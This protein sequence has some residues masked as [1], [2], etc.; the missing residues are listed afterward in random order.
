MRT[1]SGRLTL[2]FAAAVFAV[3]AASA[4]YGSTALAEQRDKDPHGALRMDVQ[5]ER[6][7]KLQGD[8]D[9]TKPPPGADPVFWNTLL[10]PTDNQMT[11][12]RIAL[13]QRLYF[14]KKLSADGT[15]ACATCHDVSRGFTDQ[16][17]VAEGIGDQLGRRN[18]PT[19]MN[20]LFMETQ[21]WDGRA[22]SL[23]KQAELP[24]INPI[25]MGQ[26]D[27]DAAV[28]SIKDD[29]EYRRMFQAAYGSAPNYGDLVKAIAAF[30]R[31]LVFLEAP[32]DRFLAGETQAMSAEAQKGWELFN[33]KARCVSCHAINTANPIGSDNRFHNIGVAA[34]TR[35]FEALAREALRALEA[36]GGIEEV[37]RLALE[38]DMSELGR[39]LV[40]KNR[41]DVGAFKTEQLRNVA[42][43]AP[44]M[45]DGSMRTLWDVMDHYN[46]GGEAN[47]YLDGGIEPLALSEDEIDAVVAL[48]FAMTDQRFA[49][50]NSRA[51]EE[52][53]K[54]AAKQR[55]FR[56][57]A[58]ASREVLPFERRV[59]GKPLEGSSGGR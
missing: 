34:R 28:A 23:E 45:H 50:E 1:T 46:K 57:T 32:F 21:F 15:V 56:D 58:L 54:I 42:L 39:F 8:R 41:A 4:S 38:T 7:A 52:Q 22:A 5:Q 43:T 18:S 16:R 29:P 13:G 55:P 6:L 37:D 11:E 24:I 30:E 49:E 3:V 35:N 12:E 19:T 47:P 26:P 9:L 17:P 59:T 31:T 20:A 2:D 51:F 33:G 48:M 40:T 36:E 53:R 25:E 44:Y 27:R 10:V 14:D